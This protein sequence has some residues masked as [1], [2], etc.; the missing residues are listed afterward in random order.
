MPLGVVAPPAM[1][2]P[3]FTL[4]GLTGGKVSRSTFRNVSILQVVHRRQPWK[5]HLQPSAGE[6]WTHRVNCPPS[7][8]SQQEIGVL[9]KNTESLKCGPLN[10]SPRNMSTQLRDQLLSFSLGDAWKA[11]G[12][13]CWEKRPEPRLGGLTGRWATLRTESPSETDG[14]GIFMKSDEWCYQK[15]NHMLKN[16]KKETHFTLGIGSLPVL[17]YNKALEA[18]AFKMWRALKVLFL[19][20]YFSGLQVLHFTADSSSKETSVDQLT[21]LAKG[22]RLS[23]GKEMFWK[24]HKT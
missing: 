23:R 7:L 4:S 20:N 8:R 6:V 1:L 22:V 24:N 11:R 17:K 19:I 14:S 10:C 2:P 5:E 15:E 16:K 13:E 3:G 9:P 12:E 21:S 18:L